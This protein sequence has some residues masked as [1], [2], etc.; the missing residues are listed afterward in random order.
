MRKIT[1]ASLFALGIAA[2]G[3]GSA[4]DLLPPLDGEFSAVVVYGRV[5]G[6]GGAPVASA[7]VGI[8][9]VRTGVCAPS[10]LFHTDST[11]TDASGNYRAI[12][13]NWGQSYTTCVHVQATPPTSAGL[14]SR[15]ATLPSV[16]THPTRMDSVRLDLELPRVP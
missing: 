9:D 8:T 14:S 16:V 12:V 1:L 4:D 3:C 13:G 11:K 2:G 15:S 5:L 6:P 7:L 10:S